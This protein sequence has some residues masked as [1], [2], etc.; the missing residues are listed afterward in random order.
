VRISRRAAAAREP[1]ALIVSPRREDP[2]RPRRFQPRRER[3]AGVGYVGARQTSRPAGRETLPTRRTSATSWSAIAPPSTSPRA[4][5]AQAIALVQQILTRRTGDG[6]VCPAR[7][8]RPDD[9]TTSRR[10]LQACIALSAGPD[11]YMRPP[12]CS[13]SA[14]WTMAR[15]AQVAATSRRRPTRA[16]GVG[17][18]ACSEDRAGSTIRTR[19]RERGLARAADRRC[20]CRSTSTPLCSTTRVNTRGPALFEQAIAS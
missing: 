4:Q 2:R 16:R 9:R 11:G 14:S 8:L 1:E 18:R 13:S 12:R 3:L 20:R 7:R 17:A 19:P 5:V 15:A 10:R 6:D